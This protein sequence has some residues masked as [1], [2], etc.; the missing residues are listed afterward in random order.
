M[1]IIFSL[2]SGVVSYLLFHFG[3]KFFS[4]PANLS[5]IIKRAGLDEH[6]IGLQPAD[7][8]SGCFSP[9]GKYYVY[10]YS[11]MNIQH[12]SS[13][14]GSLGSIKYYLQVL[15]S[16]TGDAVL[17]APLELD[18]SAKIIDI[19]NDQVWLSIYD[20][21]QGWTLPALYITG[22]NKL[23]YT[24]EDIAKLNP[25]FDL[26]KSKTSIRSLVNP[27]GRPG[28]LVEAPDG[29]P[30]L[31]DPHTA[32]FELIQ[33]SAPSKLLDLKSD[34]DVDLQ[35]SIQGFDKQ[36][37]TRKKILKK[38]RPPVYSNQDYIDP[39]FLTTPGNENKL[40]CFQ[41]YFFILSSKLTTGEQARQLSMLDTTSLQQIWTLDLPQGEQS[42][43]I[44]RCERFYI[45]S[46]QM[47]IA[48]KTHLHLIDLS[49]GK[50]IQ[51]T[52]L[53]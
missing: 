36:G 7:W 39:Y 45:R 37:G 15:N 28:I 53:F 43:H 11:I 46:N 23:K 22:E 6:L 49:S 24:A 52:P 27:T 51:S 40:Y 17:K 26:L 19:Q 21:K 32:R 9:D 1:M 16:A 14:Q 5:G 35:L 41:P 10:T 18:R 31:I 42:D 4:D 34:Q 13:K 48:N 30:Y 50:I 29:R 47:F 3:K 44:Y 8:K 25:S 2:L 12:Y 33:I 38:M 20:L